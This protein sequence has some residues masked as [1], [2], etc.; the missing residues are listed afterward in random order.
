[1]KYKIEDNHLLIYYENG[2]L[3]EDATE[4]QNECKY[5]ENNPK[6]CCSNSPEKTREYNGQFCDLMKCK[7]E[8]VD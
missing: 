3:K 1:M 7:F 8:E 4:S 6:T 2:E 5:C